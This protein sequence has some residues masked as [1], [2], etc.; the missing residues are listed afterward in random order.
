MRWEEREL[1][2]INRR[3]QHLKKNTCQRGREEIEIRSS[4]VATA[5]ASTAATTATRCR[6]PLTQERGQLSKSGKVSVN[7]GNGDWRWAARATRRA[8]P[9]TWWPQP[10]GR[11][12]TSLLKQPSVA[13]I[14]RPIVAPSRSLSLTVLLDKHWP[15]IFRQSWLAIVQCHH[16]SAIVTT[17]GRLLCRQR[18]ADHRGADAGR[19]R[20][21]VSC[22]SKPPT[23]HRLTAAITRRVSC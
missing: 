23:W 13:L 17:P 10:M 12:D 5:T 2:P 11:V 22:Q 7:N 19:D 8:P 3:R 6:R 9:P 21:P 16:W 4:T 18:A 20:P 15:Q 14:I 1:A